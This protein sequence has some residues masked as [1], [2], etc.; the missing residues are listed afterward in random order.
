MGRKK[1]SKV[2]K[3]PFKLRRRK[4]ADGRESLFI[5]R[6]VDGK[7]EYEFLKLYLVP[8]TSVKAKRENAKTLRQA[9]EIILAKTE[10][11]VDDKAQEEA[12]KDKSKMLL[13]DFIGL[14]IEEYKQRGQPTYRHLRASRTKFEKFYPGARLCDM[15]KK[16]CTDYAEWLQSEPLTPQGKPLAQATACSSF[17]ILGI[18]LSAAW[19]KGYIKNNPWKLLSFQEKIARP[20]SKREFLTLDEVRKLEDAPYEKE[21]IRRAFLFACYCGLRVGD[22]TELR[23]SDISVNGGRHFVSVVMQKN[24]KPI[25][26][27]LPAKALTWLP[28]R[29]EP[30]SSVFSL[31]SHT[32]LHKHL[33]KWAEL[34]GLERHLHFHLSRHTYGTM[35]ITAGVD[36][37]TASKMMGHADVRPT[38]VYAKIVDRKKEEAVSLIDKVF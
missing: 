3:S 36:L 5:D 20:E 38:Q 30:E 33:R 32:V 26:L 6:T 31:P 14:L 34:A 27:P 28:E 16:F 21:N 18:I 4:L 22:V 1:Q 11:M 8:E 7:H 23:W 19:Q 13:S 2:D 9:E 24:S 25:L 17:W 15:D 29:G 10:N 37:Y 12:A 35:L